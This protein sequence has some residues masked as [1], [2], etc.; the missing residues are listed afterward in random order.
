MSTTSVT[1]AQRLRE[2][3][4]GRSDAE[5]LHTFDAA[6]GLDLTLEECFMGVAQA[7]LPAKASGHSAIIQYDVV[8]PRG[9]VSYQL[10]V[11]DGT[12]TARRGVHAAPRVTLRLTF[13]DFL[14]LISGKLSG[15]AAFMFGRLKITGD[16]FFS[17]TMQEWFRQPA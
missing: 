17:R 15:A 12:C 16:V 2:K 5:I 10:I 4:R 11:R 3:L 1:P 8:M 14:R 13:P 7:F 9:V 6:G